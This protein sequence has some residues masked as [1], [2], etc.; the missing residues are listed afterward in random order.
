VEKVYIIFMQFDSIQYFF[1]TKFIFPL[2]FYL[3]IYMKIFGVNFFIFFS[4]FIFLYMKIFIFLYIK[5]IEGYICD[6]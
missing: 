1:M 4:I 3:Y 5:R 2:N 6:Q